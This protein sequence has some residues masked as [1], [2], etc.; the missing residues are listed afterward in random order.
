MKRTFINI[1]TLGC[2]LAAG[3]IARAQDTN[4]APALNL[5]SFDLIAT[6]NIFDQN[7]RPPSIIRPPI[8]Q[9]RVDTFTL[10]GTMS[11]EKG[12][13]AFFDSNR[14]EYRK[15]LKASETIAGY[16]IAEI[17][18]DGIKLAAASNK[19]INLPVG[20]QMRRVEGGRWAF[21]GRAEI[22]PEAPTTNAASADNAATAAAP[23]SAPEVPAGAGDNDVMKRLMLKRLQE[24]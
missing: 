7:R 19:T 20:T 8:R 21:T 15:A 14:S 2:L 18:P 6:R 13:F 4:A 22:V 5:K 24:K 11:Y 10:V 3:G 16:K 1:V 12:N 17:A 23:D 9:Q